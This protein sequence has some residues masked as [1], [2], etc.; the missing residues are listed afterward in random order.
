MNSIKFKHNKKRNTA[1]LYEIIVLELTKAAITKNILLQNTI[2]SLIKESFAKK[3][4]LGKELILYK[5]VYDLDG[6]ESSLV[7]KF[8]NEAKRE[9][10]SLNKKDIFAAQSKLLLKIKKVLGPGVFSNFVPNYKNLASLSQIFNKEA[11][12]SSRVL[13]ERDFIESISNKKVLNENKLVPIDNLVFRTFTEKFNQQYSFLF[14][15][16]KTL[17]SKFITSFSDNALELKI[18]LNE[19]LD[20]LKEE[21]SLAKNLPEI[22]SD[23][24]MISMLK[25]VSNMLENF[26]KEEINEKMVSSIIKIQNLT[27]EFKTND[28]NS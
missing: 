7:E 26:S 8:L 27:R 5:S 24:E 17:L 1:F 22:K 28:N 13:L 25:E 4:I 14:E 6:A 2:K 9:Y 15:E 21:T 19:E 20:R 3:T 12:I 23:F 11:I 16:Q 18:F 10:D